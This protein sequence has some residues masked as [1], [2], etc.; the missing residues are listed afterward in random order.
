MTTIFQKG[1]IVTNGQVDVIITSDVSVSF[2]LFEGVVI[3]S[4]SPQVFPVGHISKNFIREHF[5]PSRIKL[6][7]EKINIIPLNTSTFAEGFSSDIASQGRINSLIH[8]SNCS[9][10]LYHGMP[11]DVPEGL[12]QMYL[13]STELFDGHQ[14]IGFWYKGS[15]GFYPMAKQA[16]ESILNFPYIVIYEIDEKG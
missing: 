12:A 14:S 10:I 4:I 8:N 16:L 15:I 6:I 5:Q 7:S 13:A 1:N 9:E 11:A 2:D 3:H